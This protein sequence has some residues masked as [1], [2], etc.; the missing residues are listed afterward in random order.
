MRLRTQLSRPGADSAPPLPPVPEPSAPA[1]TVDGSELPYAEARSDTEAKIALF[2]ALF[3]GREDVY[4]TRWVSTR[5]GR[6][7]WSPAEDNPF[8]K[9]KNDAERV[10]WPLTDPVPLP[11][12]RPGVSCC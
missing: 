11:P 8:A 3:V 5:T 4:A 2:R 6:T 10:F 12:R 7:G 9:N 1:V